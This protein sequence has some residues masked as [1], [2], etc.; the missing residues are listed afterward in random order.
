MAGERV[1]AIACITQIHADAL[2]NGLYALIG[3]RAVPIPDSYLYAL[4]LS[5][6][7]PTSEREQIRL[8]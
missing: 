1:L 4:G 6:E 7:W 5:P 3:V 2:R 8:T